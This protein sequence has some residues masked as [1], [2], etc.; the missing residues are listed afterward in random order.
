M[1][2]RVKKKKNNKTKELD[3]KTVIRMTNYLNLACSITAIWDNNQMADKETKREDVVKFVTAYKIYL[4][5]IADK[6]QTV[7]GAVVACKLLTGIDVIE[8]ID[9]VF[10]GTLI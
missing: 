4:Q 8:V 2:Q 1:M 9:E 7:D 5:E 6:R 3:N 10:G